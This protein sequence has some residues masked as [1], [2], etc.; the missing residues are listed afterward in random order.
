MGIWNTESMQGRRGKMVKIPVDECPA[1]AVMDTAVARILARLD[2]YDGD[3]VHVFPS[4]EYSKD[5]AAAWR[6]W[7]LL[8]RREPYSWALYSEGE[9]VTI[10]YYGEGYIGDREAGAGDWEREGKAPLVISR[11]FLKANGITE[12]DYGENPG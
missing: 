12:I 8:S 2:G 5:I 3:L 4:K 10:E 7:E 1:G 9:N 11:A 6:L